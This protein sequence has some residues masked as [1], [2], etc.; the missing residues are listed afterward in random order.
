MAYDCIFVDFNE[1]KLH[2]DFLLDAMPHSRTVPF[3]S[4]YFE[5]LKTYVNDIKTDHFWMVSDLANLQHFNFDFIP[6]QHEQ[7]QIHVW[8]GSYQKEG[9]VMLI[10]TAKFKKDMHNLKY[11][12][13][14]KYINYHEDPLITWNSWVSKKFTFDDLIP[15]VKEQKERYVNYYYSDP[16]NITPSF[17][18]DTKFYIND[19]NKLNMLI[20]RFDVKEELYEYTPRLHRQEQSTPVHFDVCFI[21]NNEPQSQ[22]NHDILKK[23]L[24]DKPNRLH[25]IA[26]VK[27]RKQAY[28][29]AANKSETE[30]FYAVFAKLQINHNFRFDFVPDTLKIPRHYI[31]DCYNPVIDYTYGH[32]AVILYNRKL[33]LENDGKGL[34][35][36]LSQPHDHCSL[37]SAITTF[38]KDP[39]VLYRTTF[40]EV[41]K[42]MYS[43]KHNPTVETH[44]ILNKWKSIKSSQV[45]DTAIAAVKDANN[46]A[47]E[48]NYDFEQIFKSYEWDFVDSFYNNRFKITS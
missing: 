33:T 34:D 1:N 39:K 20:P 32:Q 29:A 21:H 14:F 3:V 22:E 48:H 38:A 23:H 47:E 10:P 12:R 5:M 4:S 7:Q 15:Q 8:N 45:N 44:Y 28:Q 9:D 6:E 35:F 16:N 18:E 46:F 26:G 43:V 37:L 40:R 13:D 11:L 25:V 27:G 30:Y 31:F 17:W 41:I 24:K 19:K 42:L 2:K 36:T